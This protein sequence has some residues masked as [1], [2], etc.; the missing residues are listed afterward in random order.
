MSQATA[1]TEEFDG[2]K[3]TVHMLPPRAAR[4]ILVDMT[5]VLAPAL[6]AMADSKSGNIASFLKDELKSGDSGFSAIASALADRLDKKML[7]DHMKALASV[8]QVDGVPLDK[9]FDAIFLGGIGTMFKWYGFALRTNFSDFIAA[10]G[11]VSFRD[12][13]VEAK[14]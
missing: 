2:K 8:T 9:I 3:F 4:D 6:G 10:L 12:P 11:N 7:D 5:K 14:G 1:K 13:K